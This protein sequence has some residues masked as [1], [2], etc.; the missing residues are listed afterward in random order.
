MSAVTPFWGQFCGS[1]SELGSAERG[2]QE[3]CQKQRAVQ[4]GDAGSSYSAH[5]IC[6]INKLALH[7]VMVYS[8]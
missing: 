4:L 8:E 7:A 2:P 5:S 3:H 6:V 1:W